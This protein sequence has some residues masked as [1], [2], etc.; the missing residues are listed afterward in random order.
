[1]ARVRLSIPPAKQPIVDAK[2]EMPLGWRRFFEGVFFR[3][4]GATD[5]VFAALATALSALPN[6]TQVIASRG[7]Q[8]GGPSEG[9]NIPI[10]LYSYVGPVAGLPT[11]ASIPA[12]Q[13]WDHAFAT[14][15]RNSG[16]GASAGT[17]CEV[18]WVAS[19]L[20]IWRING[21][22]TVVTA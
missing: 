4:G 9:G 3:L 15:G 16:E 20:N 10:G 19:G 8:F 13:S 7:L 11:T 6:T 14:D 18:I 21:T 22:A 17:G 5:S 12:P 1:M 2:G